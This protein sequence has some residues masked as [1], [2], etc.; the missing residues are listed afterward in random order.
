M[1][2]PAELV[3]SHYKPLHIQKEMM[4]ARM[5]GDNIWEIWKL[6]KHPVVDD[7]VFIS[8]NGFPVTLHILSIKGEHLADNNEIGWIDELDE[9][10]TVREIDLDDINYI[11]S[12]HGQ[13]RVDCDEDIYIEKGM[14]IPE[15]F[16]EKVVI[17][18]MEEEIETEN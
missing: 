1:Y 5:K 7:R 3:I 13:C 9:E 6:E 15:Y 18:F 14:S 12:N 17:K 11:L 10:G 16:E 8:L 2:V 4:F